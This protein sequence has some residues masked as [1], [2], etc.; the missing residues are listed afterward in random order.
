MA[1]HLKTKRPQR[2]EYRPFSS[3]D[4]PYTEEVRRANEWL[5]K[6]LDNNRALS[7]Q[8]YFR[9]TQFL[10]AARR[11]LSS[12]KGER[13]NLLFELVHR[14]DEGLRLGL[15]LAEISATNRLAI[16]LKEAKL[17]NEDFLEKVKT[18]IGAK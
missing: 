15:S 3:S 2:Q 4:Y 8:D 13:E 12:D 5:E 11:Q 18:R 9:L 7:E 17:L 16:E 1:A 6:V 14:G 10:L